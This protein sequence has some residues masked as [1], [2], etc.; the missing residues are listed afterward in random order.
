M[1]WCYPGVTPVL[2]RCYP[3]VTPVLRR[4]L[5]AFIMLPLYVSVLYLKLDIAIYKTGEPTDRR[6]KSDKSY[7]YQKAYEYL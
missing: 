5:S 1:R 4:L 6:V 3:G 7:D 2:P